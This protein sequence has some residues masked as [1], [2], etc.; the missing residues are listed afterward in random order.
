MYLTLTHGLDIFTPSGKLHHTECKLRERAQCSVFTNK[1][2][3]RLLDIFVHMEALCLHLRLPSEVSDCTHSA[4]LD[5][6]SCALFHICPGRSQAL[7]G[8]RAFFGPLGLPSTKTAQPQCPAYVHSKL[9]VITTVSQKMRMIAQ[10]YGCQ[11]ASKNRYKYSSYKISM[12][13]Q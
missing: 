2:R 12:L 9:I 10:H 3:W 1:E 5:P 4:S 8:L 6:T 7:G 13:R 11:E